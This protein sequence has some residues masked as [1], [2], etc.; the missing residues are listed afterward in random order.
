MWYRGIVKVV[1]SDE[2]KLFCP[3]YG[4]CEEVQYSLSDPSVNI[5]WAT[6]LLL[7]VLLADEACLILL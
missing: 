7:A 1:Q 4:F 3:D 2:V 6:S 5:S